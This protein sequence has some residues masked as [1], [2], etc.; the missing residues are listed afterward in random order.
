MKIFKIVKDNKKSL[1][2]KSIEVTLP[3]SSEDKETLFEML[4]YLKI[5][6]DDELANKY[7]ITY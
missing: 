6:Q 1:R 5:S 3:L 7:G 2:E 4:E